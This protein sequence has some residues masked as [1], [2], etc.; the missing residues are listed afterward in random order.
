MLAPAKVFK[1][2]EARAS[3]TALPTFSNEQ[4][5]LFE[6][7]Y[8]EGY[9]LH[10][11]PVYELWLKETHPGSSDADSMTLSEVIIRCTLYQ[12]AIICTSPT[13]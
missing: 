8:S 2:S 3:S 7:R 10:D 6:K 9:N 1:P 12:V 11:D 5:A 4:I 13:V